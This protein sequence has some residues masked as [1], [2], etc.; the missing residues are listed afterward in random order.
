VQVHDEHVIC[1]ASLLPFPTQPPSSSYRN[2]GRYGNRVTNILEQIL[3]LRQIWAYTSSHGGYRETKSTT[4]SDAHG[5]F[6]ALAVTDLNAVARGT[7]R[8]LSLQDI[9]LFWLATR[10]ISFHIRSS[11]SPA[12]GSVETRQSLVDSAKKL[13]IN[14]ASTQES[15][16]DTLRF[17]TIAKAS[18]LGSF[19]NRNCVATVFTPDKDGTLSEMQFVESVEKVYKKLVCLYKASE[20]A[21]SIDAFLEG[22]VDGLFFVCSAFFFLA[23]FGLH[24]LALSLGAA[25]L[26]LSLLVLSSAAVSSYIEGVVN[27][28]FER[29]YDIGDRVV[30]SRGGEFSNSSDNGASNGCVVENIGLLST[31]VR[32][33]ATGE[34]AT[35]SNRILS[36]MAV[37]NLSRSENALIEFHL[38]VATTTSPVKMLILQTV[39]NKFVESRPR[40]WCG[41]SAFRPT[42]IKDVGGMVGYIQYAVVAQHR[43]A[44]DSFPEILESKTNLSSFCLEVQKQLNISFAVSPSLQAAADAR[45]TSSKKISPITMSS[46]SSRSLIDEQV[47]TMVKLLSGKK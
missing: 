27:V 16:E 32:A 8:E 34:V 29:E 42:S 11:F 17:E 31:S 14:L 35:V 12:F 18:S 46:P 39:L 2:L 19:D 30:F 24:S 13:Y 4:T 26:G 43:A 10:T 15:H 36:R 21:T 20:N 3:L 33:A 28:L 40:Q 6:A 44:W 37:I 47:A 23:V 22:F 7:Q 9:F 45:R 1:L 5:Y 38:T 41:I 25:S